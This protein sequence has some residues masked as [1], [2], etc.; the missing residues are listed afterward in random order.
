MLPHKQSKDTL[1]K[2]KTV[3][4]HNSPVTSALKE[5]TSPTVMSDASTVLSSDPDELPAPT[6]SRE[7]SARVAAAAE[8]DAAAAASEG[9]LG[10][11]IRPYIIGVCGSTCSGK[12][13]LCTLLRRELKNHDVAFIP[14]DCYYR[15][16]SEEQKAQ[17]YA[18]QYDFD[19][20]RALAFE[21]LTRDLAHTVEIPKYDFSRHARVEKESAEDQREHTIRPADVIIVE[22]ILIYAAGPELRNELDCKVE[23]FIDCDSD[24]V[25]LRRLKR[26]IAERGRDFDGVQEQYL[27]FVKNSWEMFVEPSK[28]YADVIIPNVKHGEYMNTSPA[29][30]MLVHD[31][32]HRLRENT[33]LRQGRPGGDQEV[34]GSSAVGSELALGWSGA[35]CRCAAYNSPQISAVYG[36]KSGLASQRRHHNRQLQVRHTTELQHQEGFKESSQ[37]LSFVGGGGSS[38]RPSVLQQERFFPVFGGA[39]VVKTP[40]KCPAA[41]RGLLSGAGMKIKSPGLVQI[42]APQITG[43]AAAAAG[44]AASP[45]I[46]GAG[47]AP[48]IAG[49]EASNVSEDGNVDPI[50]PGGHTPQEKNNVDLSGERIVTVTALDQ[51]CTSYSNPPCGILKTVLSGGC[52]TV[53]VPPLRSFSDK[54]PMKSFAQMA[55]SVES[56]DNSSSSEEE[57]IV[58]IMAP[59]VVPERDRAAADGQQLRAQQQLD[60]ELCGK[61]QQQHGDVDPYKLSHFRRLQSD[62][63]ATPA[64]SS[65]KCI[66]R[67][68]FC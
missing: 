54:S 32:K 6:K 3:L 2:I 47:A 56:G 60:L 38:S 57:G 10:S 46:S 16:L 27:R 64:Y 58:K 25:V 63:A 21:E 61:S 41:G 40:D 4:G 53:Q 36:L 52:P 65:K 55:A 19:H 18:Q 7:A 31:I 26:D 11:K 45:V 15:Q 23:V 68:I 1:G 33:L 13:T 51:P 39:P 48:K 28:R 14:S 67:R 20:P 17:A 24:L 29:V 9:G 66:L 42:A 59:G 50:L 34:I 44:D 37:Q 49:R 12:T 8:S 30:K 5:T 43:G 62:E 35:F 22:G